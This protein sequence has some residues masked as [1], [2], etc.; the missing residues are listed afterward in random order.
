MIHLVSAYCAAHY[1]TPSAGAVADAWAML[2]GT[3]RPEMSAS[4]L[5]ARG[6]AD[7]RDRAFA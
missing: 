1:R 3:P 4:A 6:L 5:R 7:D 2:A